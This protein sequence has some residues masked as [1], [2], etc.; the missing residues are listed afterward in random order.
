LVLDRQS[1]DELSERFAPD[2]VIRRPI[3]NGSGF[4]PGFFRATGEITAHVRG[5]RAILRAPESRRPWPFTRRFADFLPG[6]N[7]SCVRRKRDRQ[8][9]FA[10][11]RF[12]TS[13]LVNPNIFDFQAG[14]VR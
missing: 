13:A 7:S 14:K 5:L 6:R 3:L 8:S 4:L 10:R 2:C 12:A 11:F 1:T 9:G